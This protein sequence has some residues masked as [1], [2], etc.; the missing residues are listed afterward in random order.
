MKNAVNTSDLVRQGI[1]A[2]KAHQHTQA[3]TLFEQA[4]AQNPQDQLAWLWLASCT[5]CLQEKHKYLR[6]ALDINPNSEL[7]KR[8]A[9]GIRRLE[10]VAPP[11]PEQHAHAAP[12]DPDASPPAASQPHPPPHSPPAEQSSQPASAPP[13]TTAGSAFPFLLGHDYFQ[14]AGR[15][16]FLFNKNNSAFLKGKAKYPSVG[17]DPNYGSHL[18]GNTI[19]V[20]VM[21]LFFSIPTLLVAMSVWA[22]MLL[23]ALTGEPVSLALIDLKNNGERLVVSVVAAFATIGTVTLFSGSLISY[24]EYRRSPPK[25]WILQGEFVSFQTYLDD[26][27]YEQKQLRV[28]KEITS[29][30]P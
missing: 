12:R 18:L 1:A 11:T 7:G 19:L 26:E 25:I 6:C 9:T 3:T 22:E 13:R 29:P 2:F 5:S 14:A 27:G 24:L 8:A 23:T 15:E 10:Q 20:G 17:P 28:H 4:V 30:T 21:M 16:Y